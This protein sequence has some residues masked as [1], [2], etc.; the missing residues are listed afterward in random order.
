MSDTTAPAK[1]TLVEVAKYFAIPIAQFR[2]EWSELT[3]A[4]KADLQAGIGN[5]TFSY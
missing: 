1:A 2:K 3:P 4:D 5:G